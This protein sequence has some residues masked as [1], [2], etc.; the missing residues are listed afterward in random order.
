MQQRKLGELDVSAI[1]LGCMGFTAAY[2]GQDEAASV[3]TLHH[4]VDR[5]ITFSTPPK[6]MAPTRMKRSSAAACA[7]SAT[8][9]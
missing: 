8:R 3:A 2:G 1:G 4:A 7:R 5:G 9:S 6:S